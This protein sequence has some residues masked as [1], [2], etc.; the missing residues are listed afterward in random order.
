VPASGGSFRLNAVLQPINRGSRGYRLS[1]LAIMRALSIR[2]DLTV[3]GAQSYWRSIHSTREN[4]GRL[5]FLGRAPQPS[6]RARRNRQ[7]ILDGKKWDWL[8][9]FRRVPV[10]SRNVRQRNGSEIGGAVGARRKLLIYRFVCRP[11]R[12][13]PAPLE[14]HESGCRLASRCLII[15]RDVPRSSAADLLHCSGGCSADLEW[16]ERA[17]PCFLRHQLRFVDDGQPATANRRDRGG[18]LAVP[19]ENRVRSLAILLILPIYKMR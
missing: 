10:P 12:L 16:V 18:E 9:L 17:I 19:E 7:R 5:Q 15:D 14:P 2:S 11:I 8:G 1:R 6:C 4:C 3:V 13:I